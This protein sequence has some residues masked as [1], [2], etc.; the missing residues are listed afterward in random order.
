MRT[1]RSEK[2]KDAVYTLRAKQAFTGGTLLAAAYKDEWDKAEAYLSSLVGI[3]IPRSKLVVDV[4]D[5]FVDDNHILR[6]GPAS[7][8]PQLAAHS[9]APTTSC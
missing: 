5:F 2:I 3:K 4:L 6:R 8:R 7:A 9:Q 1:S